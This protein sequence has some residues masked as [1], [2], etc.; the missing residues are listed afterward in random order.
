MGNTVGPREMLAETLA[1]G[2]KWPPAHP[3]PPGAGRW[4]PG[5]FSVPLSPSVAGVPDTAWG[6]EC[7]LASHGT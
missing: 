2:C 7:L 1:P 4:W 5:D 3:Q 6:P